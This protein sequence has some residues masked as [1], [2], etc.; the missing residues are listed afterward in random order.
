KQRDQPVGILRGI[1]GSL[2]VS[3][4]EGSWQANDH[5]D[6]L[7]LGNKP[8][9]LGEV[10]VVIHI[11]GKGNQ[12]SSQ[13]RGWITHREPDSYGSHIDPEASAHTRV[14]LS[15]LIRFTHVQRPVFRR[16]STSQRS[17]AHSTPDAYSQ[18]RRILTTSPRRP[19]GADRS[20][21]RFPTGRIRRPAPYRPSLLPVRTRRPRTPE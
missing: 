3:V 9:D 7:V 2:A 8:N 13:H 6:H 17:S 1:L 19:S 11:T 10:A 5:F 16:L 14:S 18:R 15:R 21:D 4:R 12:R 20:P